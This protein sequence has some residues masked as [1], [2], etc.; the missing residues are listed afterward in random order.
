V[1]KVT[2]QVREN[3]NMHC[4]TAAAAANNAL[5]LLR[6]VSRYTGKP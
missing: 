6:R 4:N 3:G 5:W 1:T 2:A